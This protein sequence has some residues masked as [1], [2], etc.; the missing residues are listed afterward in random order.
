MQ[1]TKRRLVLSFFGLMLGGVLLLHVIL[2]LLTG[3]L[4]GEAVLPR[5]LNVPEL[6][7][8]LLI[9]LIVTALWYLLTFHRKP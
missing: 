8:R 3:L 7:G 9:A 2:A 4:D 6:L 5:I 1:K